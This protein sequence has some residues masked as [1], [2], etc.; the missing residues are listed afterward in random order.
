MQFT[1]NIII[2]AIV[3]TIKSGTIERTVHKI[4]KANLRESDSQ[5]S[6]YDI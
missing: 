1:K 2:N 4:M 6:I 5:T 3:I